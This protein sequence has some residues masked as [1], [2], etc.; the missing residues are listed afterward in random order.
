ML[1]HYKTESNYSN[2]FGV[3]FTIG[4]G[5]LLYPPLIFVLPLLGAGIGLLVSTTWRHWAALIWGLVMPPGIAAFI[6]ML[7]GNLAYQAGSF[8]N[9]FEFSVEL[10]PDFIREQPFLAAWFGLI[11][12]WIIIA[13]IGYR[14]PRIQSRQLFMV[15]F[16]LFVILVAIS[17]FMKSI[18]SEIT[19][20]LIIPVSFLIT[21]WSL[22]VRKGWLRDLFFLSMMGSWLFLQLK[23]LVSGG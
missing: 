22:N 7:T 18:S 10:P 9:W 20:F 23:D 1:A 5:T 13:S 6:L 15:N 19:W 8:L 16:F 2:S 17:L 21:F 11:L 12:I 4:L 14:N 3:G